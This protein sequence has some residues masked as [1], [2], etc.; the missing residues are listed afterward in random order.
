[1]FEPIDKSFQQ[2]I[3]TSYDYCKE[4]RQSQKVTAIVASEIANNFSM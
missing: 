4:L 3:L 2:T 1:M